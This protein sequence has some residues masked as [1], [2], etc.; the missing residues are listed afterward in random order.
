VAL[1]ERHGDA[2]APGSAQDDHAARALAGPKESGV[3]L[4]PRDRIVCES[5][6]SGGLGHRRRHAPKLVERDLAYGYITQNA[7]E[8]STR[9]LP[10]TIRPSVEV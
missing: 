9:A 4:F 3:R 7:A 2:E 10:R 6:G 1:S 5:A 8:R